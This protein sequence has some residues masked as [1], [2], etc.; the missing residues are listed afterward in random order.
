MSYDVFLGQ[1]HKTY[2]FDSPQGFDCFDHAALLTSF[3][4]DLC[5]V[6][7]YYHFRAVAEPRQDHQ[8]LQRHCVLGLV[9][10]DRGLIK[11][12]ASHKCER[13]DLDDVE[14]HELFHLGEVHH[15]FERVE[16]RT[17]IGV[18]LGLHDARKEAELFSC[19]DGRPRE[20]DSSDLLLS[21]HRDRD[22]HS[23]IGLA[24]SGRAY[25]EGQVVAQHC[26][27]VL[28]L[29]FGGRFNDLLLRVYGDSLACFDVLGGIA[30]AQHRSH[31]AGAEASVSEQMPL[32]F[33]DD[34]DDLV[35]VLFLADDDQIVLARSNPNAEG[36]AQ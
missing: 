5:Y 12:P 24:G 15:V 26:L 4:V 17:K 14:F 32:H 21:Q 19:F 30:P 1:L 13:N 8:H 16:E 22:R 23:Q 3:E 11:C 10:D 36:F 29:P 34:L 27:Y 31:I 35:D 9:T 28:E 20:Y 7:G 25:A 2:A 18:D 6:A 33:V